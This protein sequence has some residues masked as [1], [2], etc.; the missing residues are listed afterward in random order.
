MKK[1]D[2]LEIVRDYKKELL[3][4]QEYAYEV[5]DL[6]AMYPIGTAI[7]MIDTIAELLEDTP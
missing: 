4:D 7:K 3:K 6:S 2:I 5:S 1:E